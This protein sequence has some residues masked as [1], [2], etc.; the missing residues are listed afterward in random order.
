MT[1]AADKTYAPEELGLCQ[2]ESSNRRIVQCVGRTSPPA[3]RRA[4]PAQPASGTVVV[5]DSSRVVIRVD[6]RGAGASRWP[7]SVFRGTLQP[8]GQANLP[9]Q[10]G[11]WDVC[12]ESA[13]GERRVGRNATLPLRLILGDAPIPGR[14][15]QWEP[16]ECHAVGR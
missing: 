3:A 5:N 16:G 13:R 6:A 10:P 9:V 15:V 12:Y 14:G 1:A 4:G 7:S 11:Q 8:G 2:R